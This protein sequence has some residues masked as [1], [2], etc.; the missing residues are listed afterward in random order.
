MEKK[1]QDQIHQVC[2]YILANASQIENPEVVTAA[3][4]L[5][6]SVLETEGGDDKSAKGE[7]EDV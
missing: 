5:L 7:K 3:R 1:T 6:K 2:S 4:E